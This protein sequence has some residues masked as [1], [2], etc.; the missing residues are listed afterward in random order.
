MGSTSIICDQETRVSS[1]I[2]IF[3]SVIIIR[4]LNSIRDSF[5]KRHFQ[6]N[7]TVT[8]GFLRYIEIILDRQF[9]MF[10]IWILHFI[11]WGRGCAYV[12]SYVVYNK[13]YVYKLK[14]NN[15]F[16]Q[17]SFHESTLTK[18]NSIFRW[19]QYYKSNLNL[20]RFVSLDSY[21]YKLVDS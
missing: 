8:I 11:C 2:T 1:F 9:S 14:S 6:I 19:C 17:K 13:E 15:E 3:C 20:Q 12:A 18:W 21:Y 4:F 10:T 7:V 5:Q 16:Y